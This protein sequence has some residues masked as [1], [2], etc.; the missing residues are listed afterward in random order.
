MT[1]LV[2]D[3]FCAGTPPQYTYVDLYKNKDTQKEIDYALRTTGHIVSLSGE[4]RTGKTVLIKHIFTKKPHI[5]VN[6]G[7]L[8]DRES[9][10][11]VWRDISYKV[12]IPDEETVSSG[13][14]VGGAAVARLPL[15]GE[16]SAK[17]GMSGSKSQVS[18]P[19]ARPEIII[20]R[21]I[22]QNMTLIIDDF[23]FIPKD[24]KVQL[25]LALKSAIFE[26]LKVIIISV[27]H[28]DMDAIKAEPDL[29]GRFMAIRHPEWQKEDI[30]QIPEK[31]F[32]VLRVKYSQGLI[33]KICEESQM[34]PQLTQDI[35]RKICHDNDIRFHS[36][37][38]QSIPETYNM[39]ESLRKMAA[40]KGAPI[41]SQLCIGPISRKKRVLR[42]LISGESVDIYSLIMRAIAETGPQKTILYDSLRES[43]RKIIIKEES[44]PSK[45][46]ITR[47]LSHMR[48]ISIYKNRDPAID[49]DEQSR[50]IIV[51]DSYLR[52]YLRWQ[53]RKDTKFPPASGSS[54]P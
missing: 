1:V 37:L 40:E 39:T 15:F 9:L 36:M 47:S 4:S 25:L 2:E 35:C 33:E 30:I 43:I 7:S 46:D 8:K 26:G 42:K 10:D 29:C 54:R 6:S 14:E 48:D 3:V 52:F 16:T 12:N 24:I 19:S 38:P 13:S 18:Q 23:H 31:G 17:L 44:P 53:I 34:N 20:R 27:P 5:W 51:A 49:W 32:K 11:D 21:L 22:D 45:S 50:Q 28:R 41:F